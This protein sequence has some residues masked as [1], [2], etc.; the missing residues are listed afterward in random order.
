MLKDASVFAAMQEGTPYKSYI[1]TVRAK[2]YV[3]VLNPLSGEPEGKILFGDPRKKDET[4]IVDV[5]DVQQDLFL[6]RMNKRHF[7][8]GNIITYIRPNSKEE[9]SH[10]EITDEQLRDLLDARRNKF[11]T[12]QHKVNE[13]VDIAPLLRLRDLAEDEEKSEKI[14]KCIDAKISELQEK[15]YTR[16]LEQ[17]EE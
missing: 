10:K 9:L 13:F 17:L 2:V 4:C 1:K 5:W 15:E 11:L 7:D 3:T 6:R 12:F 14:L 8:K 16:P